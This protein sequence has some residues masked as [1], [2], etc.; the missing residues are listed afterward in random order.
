MAKNWTAYEAAKE[1]Y[2]NNKENIAE[3][4]SRYPLLTRVVCLSNDAYLLD[5]LAALPKVTARV[6][7]TG[8]KEM[9]IEE[10]G[11]DENV[12]NETPAK[13]ETKAKKAKEV[14]DEEDTESGD[15]ESMTTKE[16]YNECCKRGISGKC[17]NRKK[18]TL[19]AM[20][21]AYDNGEF[22]EEEEEKPAKKSGGKKAAKKAPEP[23]E[24]DEDDWGDDEEEEKDPYAG[25]SAKELYKM[26]IDRGI[27]TKQ[28]LSPDKYVALL[29]KADEAENEEET[30]DEDDDWEI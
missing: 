20:L 26:C 14:E 27:K 25:K 11:Q 24:E 5:V 21:E 6:L 19:I 29:K 8:L 17:K 16:L 12:E 22:E 23:V 7:E 15:Y 1:L 28:K 13:K 4:G 3:I 18:D 30:E 9:D 2:G 10:E